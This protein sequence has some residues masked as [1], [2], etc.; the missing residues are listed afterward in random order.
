M[1]NKIE[2]L[3]QEIKQ[4]QQE[5]VALRKQLPL[6]EIKNYEFKNIDGHTIDLL[7]LFQ[8]SNELLI[9]HNMGK[10]CRYCTMWADGL[11]GYSQ[12]MNDRMPWVLTSPDSYPVLKEFAESRNWNFN[13]LS[14]KGTTFASDLGFEYMKE[15]RT[16]YQ[17]G[18]SALIKK[19]HKI[20][21]AGK[22]NFG[23]GDFYNPVWH[24]FDLFP[25][26]AKD[27]QPKYKY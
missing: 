2:A 18:V 19:E 23:P 10:S 4:K 1:N 25:E 22:D 17:P 26:G 27:W 24:F 13:C 20:F 16:I 12:I 14:F 15:G 8:E 9:I 7:S 3:Q 11:R 5:L 6:E 21:R